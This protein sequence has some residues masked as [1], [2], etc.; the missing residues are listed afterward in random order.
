MLS[1]GSLKNLPQGERH[2][3]LEKEE[4]TNM[5]RLDIA[6]DKLCL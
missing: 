1:G 5:E 6:E 2:G 4:G 3:T